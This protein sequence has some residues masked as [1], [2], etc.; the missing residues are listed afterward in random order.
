LA[1]ESD[2]AQT[3]DRLRGRCDEYRQT[4]K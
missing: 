1:S 4:L 2:H 3:L